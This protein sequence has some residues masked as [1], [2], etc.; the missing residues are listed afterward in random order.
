MFST[1]SCPLMW[2]YAGGL[3]FPVS[4][5]LFQ[6]CLLS[7]HWSTM[8]NG[9]HASNSFKPPL[10]SCWCPL[11]I[12]P[13]LFWDGL[14]VRSVATARF[15]DTMN[16]ISKRFCPNLPRC[17][18]SANACP[19]LYLLPAIKRSGSARNL[20]E[21]KKVDWTLL[22]SWACVPSQ[23]LLPLFLSK[24]GPLMMDPRR[25]GH[26]H[27][28]KNLLRS[29]RLT[30]LSLRRPNFDQNIKLIHHSQGWGLLFQ[31]GT[32]NANNNFLCPCLLET[33]AMTLN[34]KYLNIQDKTTTTK[35]RR[36]NINKNNKNTEISV[37]RLNFRELKGHWQEG[38][39]LDWDAKLLQLRE[40]WLLSG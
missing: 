27:G 37:H 12:V 31:V 1:L 24:S 26:P 22:W 23:P 11:S 6:G 15:F 4:P 10:R 36:L 39:C 33:R 28:Q 16:R 3:L 17:Q 32:K 7:M 2:Y 14:H 18:K 8:C 13:K 38:E 29:P 30:F 34:N 35:E 21:T 40:D 20:C 19:R 9:P 25:L 5:K